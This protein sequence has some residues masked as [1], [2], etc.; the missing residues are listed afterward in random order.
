MSV[1]QSLSLFL[2]TNNSNSPDT[3]AD[4]NFELNFAAGNNT[5]NYSLSLESCSFPNSVYP[6]NSNNNKIYFKENGG[7]TLEA[8]LQSNNYTGTEFAT[9]IQTQLD[10]AGA[11]TYTVTYDSQSK[12]ITI[13]ENAANTIQLVAGD[14]DVY[15]NIGFIVTSADANSITADNPVRLD[16]SLFIDIITNIGTQNYSSSGRTNVLARIPLS[17]NFGN[18]IFYHDESETYLDLAEDDIGYIETRLLD[19]KGNTFDLPSNANVSY[20]LRLTKSH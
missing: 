4:T 10:A 7:A 8:T 18:V 2:D 5:S 17:G 14:N 15:D 3:P 9:Q 19:D 20:V 1:V 13:T 12:K 11:N 16:G 6:I